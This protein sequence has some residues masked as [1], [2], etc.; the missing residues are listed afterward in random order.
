MISL[1]I[2]CCSQPGSRD[3]GKI[4]SF[5]HLHWASEQNCIMSN[6]SKSWISRES[7][8]MF[9]SKEAQWSIIGLLFSVQSPH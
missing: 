6:R 1:S 7:A 3:K 9:L 8:K 5:N 4:N 2:A